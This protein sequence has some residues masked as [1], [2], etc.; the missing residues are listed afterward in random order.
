MGSYRYETRAKGSVVTTEQVPTETDPKK[1]LTNYVSLL[2]GSNATQVLDMVES[3]AVLA[4][5]SRKIPDTVKQGQD[6]LTILQ[7]SLQ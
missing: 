6:A 5:T 1:I 4:R 2:Q 7:Q 3:M